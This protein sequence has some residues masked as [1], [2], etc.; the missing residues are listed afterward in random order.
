MFRYIS[1]AVLSQKV[2]AN[3]NV[4][5]KAVLYGRWLSQQ[6]Q[7]Q[8]KDQKAATE[9]ASSVPQSSI[10][11]QSTVEQSTNAAQQLT[12]NELQ[13]NDLQLP[14]N[15][16]LIVQYPPNYKPPDTD[17]WRRIFHMHQMKYFAIFSKLKFYPIV[18]GGVCASV[19]GALHAFDVLPEASIMTPLT[20]GK[21]IGCLFAPPPRF[22]TT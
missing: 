1:G 9:Q 10:E 20:L 17:V 21:Y 6:A 18:I 22:S 4:G 8:P 16:Q 3:Q 15:R 12:A 14:L 11:Q 7:A 5:R 2:Y 13:A 19:T